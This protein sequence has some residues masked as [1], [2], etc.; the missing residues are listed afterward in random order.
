MFQKK[1]IFVQSSLAT[2]AL[3]SSKNRTPSPA[4]TPIPF[5]ARVAPPSQATSSSAAIHASTSEVF[6]FMPTPGLNIQNVADPSNYAS[7]EIPMEENEE[8]TEDE[9]E[10]EVVVGE[11]MFPLI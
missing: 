2:T 6:R 10:D 1:S 3:T 11:G 9:D 8:E 5:T 4:P 7:R